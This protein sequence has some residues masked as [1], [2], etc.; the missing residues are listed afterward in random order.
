MI[1]GRQSITSTI[2]HRLRRANLCLRERRPI[3]ARTKAG[4]DRNAP[5][6]MRLES[7]TKVLSLATN[8]SIAIA[9]AVAARVGFMIPT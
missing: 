6:I 8:V 5:T 3:S 1:V 7:G 9:I 4:I 2:T